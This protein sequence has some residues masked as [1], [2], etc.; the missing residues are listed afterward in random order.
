MILHCSPSICSTGTG[1]FSKFSEQLKKSLAHFVSPKMSKVSISTLSLP[2]TGRHTTPKKTDGNTCMLKQSNEDF[3][4]DR[5]ETTGKTYIQIEAKE[6][7]QLQQQMSTAITRIQQLEEEVMALKRSNE[8]LMRTTGPKIGKIYERLDALEHT[9]YS[10]QGEKTFAAA[11]GA[12]ATPQDPQ[13]NKE[14][15]D[16]RKIKGDRD[17]REQ[18]RSRLTFEAIPQWDRNSH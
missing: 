8:Q 11:T 18:H 3:Q 2:D 10:S 6:F 13:K 12:P 16:T 14:D 1:E 15:G 7:H 5:N 9:G 4:Q 17:K